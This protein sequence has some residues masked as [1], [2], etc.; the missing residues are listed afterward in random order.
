MRNTFYICKVSQLSNVV[1]SCHW[2]SLKRY[3]KIFWNLFGTEKSI[4]TQIICR[5]NETNVLFLT[6]LIHF[7]CTI[8]VLHPSRPLTFSS[9]WTCSDIVHLCVVI[10]FSLKMHS[11]SRFRSI[12]CCSKLLF[13][14]I[15]LK[16]KKDTINNKYQNGENMFFCFK[17]LSWKNNNG[18]CL[19][20]LHKIIMSSFVICSS[21][22]VNVSTVQQ[23]LIYILNSWLHPP[24]KNVIWLP[25]KQ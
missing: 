21:K 18:F 24:K 19:S 2:Q 8:F 16:Q 22:A 9:V 12:T 25:S 17:K 1:S 10:I 7:T 3:R 4:A 15:I 5:F 20:S 11:T 14:F 13:K 23:A 6:D